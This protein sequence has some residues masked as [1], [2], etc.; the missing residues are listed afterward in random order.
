VIVGLFPEVRFVLI[1]NHGPGPRIK[2]IRHTHKQMRSL[3]DF[4]NISGPPVAAYAC[5][6]GASV[7]S[8]LGSLPMMNTVGNWM[9]LAARVISL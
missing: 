6:C 2:L 3:V 8:C 5:S 9:A 4:N 7:L 1:R